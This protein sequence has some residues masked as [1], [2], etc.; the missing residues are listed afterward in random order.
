[1]DDSTWPSVPWTE[2]L[3]GDFED[4]YTAAYDAVGQNQAIFRPSG[5]EV[6]Q[7]TQ[8]MDAPDSSAVGEWPAEECFFP[9]DVDQAPAPR[10]PFAGINGN[11]KAS[12]S[13]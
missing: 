9:C 1:M 12:P 7:T 4:E 3:N 8:P 11:A 6:Y 2:Y 13:K 5:D 10:T